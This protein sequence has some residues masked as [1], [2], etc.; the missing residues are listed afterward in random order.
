MKTLAIRGATTVVSNTKA[1][2]LDETAKLVQTI[3]IE[4]TLDI[5]DIV[6]MCFTM[7]ND[8][9]KVYPSVAVRD[10]LDITDVPMLNFEEK[11]IEGSLKMCVRIMMYV[12]TDKSKKDIK[13]I[14]LNNAK[15]LRKDLITNEY[16]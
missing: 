1:D 11:Y 12:N 6:S 15:N 3:I 7:T 5:D 2:I 16:K 14:Y 8:L 13:H 4:N 9:D 10:I